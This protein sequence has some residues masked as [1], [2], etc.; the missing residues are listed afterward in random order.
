MET[1][2]KARGKKFLSPEHWGEGGTKTGG[3][4]EAPG[5]FKGCALSHVTN[6]LEDRLVLPF[7]FISSL[8]SMCL[9]YL[10]GI[11]LLLILVANSQSHSLVL[12][13]WF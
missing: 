8:T 13:V 5:A 6:L 7:K 1:G 11:S 9:R 4:F 10:K 12:C 2:E 3:G